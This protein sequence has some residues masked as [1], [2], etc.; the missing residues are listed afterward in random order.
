MQREE[1]LQQLW[2]DYIH[3]HPDVGMLRL[4]PTDAPV[5]YLTLVTLNQAP[6]STQDLLP[7]LGHLGY[8]PVHRYAMA[9]RG[10]LVCLL[11]PPEDSTWLVLAE[12]QLGALSRV[13]RESLTRLVSQTHPRDTRGK[14]LL[15]RGRPWPMPDWD[16]YEM[17]YEAHPLAGWLSVMG[18]SVHHAGF[19]CE[20]LGS[21]FEELDQALAASGFQ[22]SQEQQQAVL[23]VSP[24]LKYR[25][26][27]TC[28]Q[29]MAFGDG[30]EHRICLGG[31]ALIQ[32]RLSSDHERAV[33]LLL[34]HHTRCEM[35]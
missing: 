27:P 4:W 6:F 15:S 23:P 30:D 2:L 12:L 1:F 17:L 33:E 10:L 8:R 26:Y 11:A 5:E 31:L 9:D 34:P 13:P 28:S 29:R 35:T 3:H 21:R 24:L 25:F 22:G 16:D 14:N 20:R 32:K 19:D 18:P 7:T